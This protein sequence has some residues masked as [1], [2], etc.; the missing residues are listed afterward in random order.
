M[1]SSLLFYKKKPKNTVSGQKWTSSLERATALLMI[2][3]KIQGAYTWHKFTRYLF[4]LVLATKYDKLPYSVK[5]WWLEFRFD[6]PVS[7][8]VIKLES[9]QLLDALPETSI[10][11]SFAKLRNHDAASDASCRSG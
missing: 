8:G 10:E 2:R 3:I 11:K 4:I 7:P 9:R 1:S 6:A 5:D